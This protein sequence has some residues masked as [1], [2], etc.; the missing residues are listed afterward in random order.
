MGV[1][2]VPIVYYEICHTNDD[3]PE[4]GALRVTAEEESP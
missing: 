1:A 4:A 3:T 2:L